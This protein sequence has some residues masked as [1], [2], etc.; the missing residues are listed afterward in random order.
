MPQNSSFALLDYRPYSKVYMLHEL[1]SS[2][3]LGNFWQRSLHQPSP[4]KP[5]RIWNLPGQWRG[6]GWEHLQW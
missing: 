5:E 2:L 4:H 1:S 3:L 6:R